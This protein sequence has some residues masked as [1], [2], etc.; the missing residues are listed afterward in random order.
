MPKPLRFLIFVVL[1]SLDNAAAG[2]VP[3]LYAVMARDF[4]T[5]EARL[6]SVTAVYILLIALSA[7]FIG[8]RSDQGQRKQWLFWGTLL[9]GGAMVLSGRA[10]TVEQFFLWQAVTAVGIGG[11]SA[12][13]FSVVSDVV[14]PARRGVALSLWATAQTLGG[15]LGAGLATIFGGTNWRLPFFVIAAAG[16]VFALLYLFFTKPTR[17]G[18]AEP[19]LT[20]VYAAGKSYEY[21]ITRADLRYILARHSNRWLLLQRFFLALALGSTIWIPRWAIARV[22]A[23]GYSLN[24]ATLIGNLFVFLFNIGGFLAIP[25]GHLG[26]RW[27]RQHPLG[28]LHLALIGLLGS[29]PF[30][31]I[32]YFLPLRGVAIPTNGSLFAVIGTILWELFT[33]G[34]VALAFI[35]AL[36]GVGLF[37]AEPPNWA[38]LITDLNLPEQ[39]GTVIGLSRLF[40]AIGNALSVTLTGWLITLLTGRFDPPTNYAIGLALFQLPLLLAAV[41]YWLMRRHLPGDLTAVRTLLAHRA[42]QIQLDNAAQ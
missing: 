28:R 15:G 18:E 39:R 8:Y 6:G 23:E 13:G 40:S 21:R 33:N 32:L 29:I 10:Q 12:V 36:F 37:A 19:E 27:Q 9:W 24:D 26:D 4:A 5:S 25:A 35:V 16:F 17:R 14:P 41:C 31:V 34:Y 2:V 38:A 1:A 22:Q 30:F 20:A 42:R 11:V 3:P 7:A